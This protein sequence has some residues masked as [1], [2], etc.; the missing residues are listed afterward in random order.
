LQEVQVAEFPGVRLGQASIER[1]GQLELAQRGG[2]GAAA[3]AL[4][5]VTVTAVMRLSPCR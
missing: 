4:R 2:Q 5:S 1:A 3:R